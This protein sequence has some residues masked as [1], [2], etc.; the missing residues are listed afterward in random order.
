MA[1]YSAVEVGAAFGYQGFVAG[2]V[3]TY[4]P[5]LPARP[6]FIVGLDASGVEVTRPSSPV[7]PQDGLHAAPVL[8]ATWP[9]T[10][11]WEWSG[12][13]PYKW[14]AFHS[15]DGGKTFVEDDFVTGDKRVYSPDGGDKLMYIIGQDENSANVTGISNLVR[16][17]D[18]LAP[19]PVISLDEIGQFSWTWEHTQPP[20]WQLMRSYDGV[21]FQKEA[22]LPGAEFTCLIEELDWTPYAIYGCDASGLQL[23][24]MSNGLAVHLLAAPAADAGYGGKLG[25]GWSGSDPAGWNIYEWPET[26]EAS[27]QGAV[28]G[29]GRVYA[30]V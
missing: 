29:T 9:S 6:L 21:H 14:V 18:A 10:A 28:A 27:F 2:S 7:V 13:D 8:K 11:T 19:A 3:R 15:L 23:T 4:T 16:P 12:D 30:V 20:F 24:E 25:W 22:V 5:G 1:I 26:G 17:D